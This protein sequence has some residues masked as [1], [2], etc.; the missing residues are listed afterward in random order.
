MLPVTQ[1]QF[2][3]ED[4]DFTDD[5]TM[6]AIDEIELTARA[7]LNRM[8]ST[9]FSILRLALIRYAEMQKLPISAV[10]PALK[11][12]TIPRT[13]C[14]DIEIAPPTRARLRLK[15]GWTY[16]TKTKPRFVKRKH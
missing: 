2:D 13:N 1:A 16:R 5:L 12:F 3:A 11:R 9:N 15:S 7:I 8:P 6:G 10:D 4:P 14:D